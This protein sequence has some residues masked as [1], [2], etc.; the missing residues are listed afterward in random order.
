[1]KEMNLEFHLYTGK[2]GQK[3]SH[4]KNPEKLFKKCGIIFSHLSVSKEFCGSR[5]QK[6]KA[7]KLKQID[8]LNSFKIYQSYKN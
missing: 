6:H 8:K 3:A 1:M 5:H 7:E 2:R 4:V